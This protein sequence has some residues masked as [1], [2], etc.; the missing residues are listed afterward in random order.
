MKST[1]ARGVVLA[2]LM[3]APHCGAMAQTRDAGTP[4]MIAAAP[5]A[6]VGVPLPP[7]GGPGGP[8]GMRGPGGPPGMGGPPPGEFPPGG[9]P[10]LRPGLHFPPPEALAPLD[11]SDSQRERID[12]LRD[13][14]RRASIRLE[15]EIRLA[16]MDVE[17]VIASD[18][19][20]ERDLEDALTHLEDVRTSLLRTHAKAIIEMRALL[21]P[22]QRA[23][24]R[25]PLEPRWH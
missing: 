20:S 22:K 2:L 6:D 5:R 12:A 18:E 9:P 15:A 25:R 16:E 11:L 17:E 14:V 21:S 23:K 24:L 7:G 1:I 3:V 13:K 8:D 19:P 10:G 4:D